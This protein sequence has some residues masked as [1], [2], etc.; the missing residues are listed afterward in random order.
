ME[1]ENVS[2]SVVSD[3]L[4]ERLT[5]MCQTPMDAAPQGAYQAPLFM[6]FSSTEYGVGSHS[7]LQGIFPTQG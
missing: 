7:L 2:R 6:E 4:Q 1:S 3:S 5:P